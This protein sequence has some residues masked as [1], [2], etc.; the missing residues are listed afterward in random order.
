MLVNTK[1]CT[2]AA[3]AV[4]CVYRFADAKATT[5]TAGFCLLL[6]SALQYCLLEKGLQCKEGLVIHRRRIQLVN[7]FLLINTK[8]RRN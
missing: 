7:D 5:T 4:L 2:S 8:W 1:Y 3:A 6:I